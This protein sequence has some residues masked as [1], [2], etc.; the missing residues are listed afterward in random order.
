MN[1]MVMISHP[2][3]ASDFVATNYRP[4]GWQV[5]GLQ[6]TAS[7][8]GKKIPTTHTVNFKGKERRIYCDCFSNSGVTY[9]M[10]KGEKVYVH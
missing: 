4:L 6:K 8:Y 7:G 10:V 3:Y 2:D 9:I 5:R 1:T